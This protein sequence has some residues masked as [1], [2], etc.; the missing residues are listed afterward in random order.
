MQVFFY[1]FHWCLLYEFVLWSNSHQPSLRIR[2]GTVPFWAEIVECLS[3]VLW[4]D[5]GAVEQPVVVQAL[6]ASFGPM[7]W[8]GQV[9]G[10]S[11]SGFKGPAAQPSYCC[12]SSVDAVPL[13]RSGHRVNLKYWCPG[14]PG[15]S[16][17]IQYA[18][19][20]FF[21]SKWTSSFHL[22]FIHRGI[23]EKCFTIL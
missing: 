16:K 19:W 14:V 17:N 5:A 21:P 15:W 10:S 18:V 23:F 9:L 4:R 7:W 13:Y 6:L 11:A 1:A 22:W 8:W 2:G 20:K 3:L 12:W